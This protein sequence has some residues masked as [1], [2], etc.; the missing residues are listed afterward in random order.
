MGRKLGQKHSKKSFIIR[1]LENG[2]NKLKKQRLATISKL[3]RLDREI[4]NTRLVLSSALETEK[5]KK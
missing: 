3:N 1:T 4:A 2:L 5:A